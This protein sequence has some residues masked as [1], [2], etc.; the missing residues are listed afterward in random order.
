MR[1]KKLATAA[2]I[3]A[4]ATGIATGTA[5]AAPAQPAAHPA[6]V[7]LSGTDHGVRYTTGPAGNGAATVTTLKSGRFAATP[8]GVTVSDRSGSVIA[9]LPMAYR[10]AGHTYPLRATV[11]SSGRSLTLTPIGVTVTDPVRQE[12]LQRNFVDYA[13][14]LARHQYNAGV[15]A[16]IGAGVG[17]LIGF[18]V[19]PIIGAIPGAI[20]GAAV[21]AGIGWVSP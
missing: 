3:V 10:V 19:I 21:G 17:A 11:D 14:D 7:S 12:L 4:T 13:A 18:F 6:G 16:L 2:V 9:T 5:T 20:I 1:T 15:G 8:D